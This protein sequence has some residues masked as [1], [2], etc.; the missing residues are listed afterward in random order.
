ML[1]RLQNCRLLKYTLRI[2]IGKKALESEN[3][4]INTPFCFT[5]SIEQIITYVCR[6]VNS[7]DGF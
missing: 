6:V 5:I 1:A 7:T 3:P 2:D 4:A